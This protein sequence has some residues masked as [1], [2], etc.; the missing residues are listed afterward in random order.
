MNYFYDNNLF[1]DAQFGFLPCRS[2]EDA[3]HNI[4]DNIYRALDVRESVEGVFLVLSKA[5]DSQSRGIS[6][7]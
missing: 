4:V 2:T 7:A 5:F 1:A 3:V 6:C